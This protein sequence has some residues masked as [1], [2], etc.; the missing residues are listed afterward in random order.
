MEPPGRETCIGVEGLKG[1]P[2]GPGLHET[3]KAMDIV[4][5]CGVFWSPCV[6]VAIAAAGACGWSMRADT[7]GY[8]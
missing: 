6:K 2:P 4:E 7:H 5:G 1:T 3:A 8:E